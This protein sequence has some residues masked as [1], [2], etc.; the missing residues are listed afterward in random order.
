MSAIV[1]QLSRT[2]CGTWKGVPESPNGAHWKIYVALLATH[3][4]WPTYRWQ[5]ARRRH[6]IPT[7]TERETTLA[8]LGYRV[9]ADAEWRWVEDTGPDYHGHAP[10]VI[11]IGAIDVVPLDQPGGTA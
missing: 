1:A 4:E 10:Q 7:L 5:G 9:A 6:A 2:C 3:Q 11:L 8:G